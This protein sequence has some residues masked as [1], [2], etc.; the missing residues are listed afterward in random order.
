MAGTTITVTELHDGVAA[1]F[2]LENFRTK[3]AQKLTSTHQYSLSHGLEIGI[4]ETKLAAEPITLLSSESIKP[5]HQRLRLPGRLRVEVFAGIS[6][7]NPE[8]AG[9]YVFCNGRLV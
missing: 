7:S 4:G 3:L 6:P 8:K 5:L 2:G 1:Q 9:W